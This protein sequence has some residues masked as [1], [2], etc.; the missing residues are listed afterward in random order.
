MGDGS[1]G[2]VDRIYR[3]AGAATAMVDRGAGTHYD[4]EHSAT[5]P[6]AVVFNP[7]ESGKRGERGPD[8][9]DDG[10]LHMLCVESAIATT[11][12]LLQPGGE[13]TGS[14]TIRVQ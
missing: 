8:F 13:W 6:D 7:W 11:P 14:Q 5:W 1:E 9:D 10:Y 2:F 3:K 12:I 4:I